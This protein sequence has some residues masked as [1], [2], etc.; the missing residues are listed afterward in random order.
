KLRAKFA[1]TATAVARAADGNEAA[2]LISSVRKNALQPISCEWAGP[3]NEVWLRFG[4]HPRAVDWQLTNLPA[5]DW[6]VLEAEDEAAAWER[7]RLRYSQLGP[8]ALRVVGLPTDVGAILE[9]YRP[10]TWIAH[11][12]NGIVLMQVS[13]TEEIRHVRTK[14]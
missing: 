9:E 4:E 10:R 7:F 13:G 5:G 8:V 1:R 11:A 12:L 6:T 3:E 2:Q 14:Y